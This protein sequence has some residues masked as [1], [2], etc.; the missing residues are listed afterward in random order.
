MSRH[1]C[2]VVACVVFAHYLAHVWKAPDALTPCQRY[3]G[4]GVAD[5]MC[6]VVLTPYA[7]QTMLVCNVDVPEQNVVS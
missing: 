6:L 4:H 1:T 7:S 3:S 2:I 5:K